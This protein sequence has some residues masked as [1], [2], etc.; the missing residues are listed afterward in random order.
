MS[1]DRLRLQRQLED[2][3]K[4]DGNT[5]WERF[6]DTVRQERQLV[7]ESLGRGESQPE[8][9]LRYL[10]GVNEALLRIQDFPRR[11]KESLEK[12]LR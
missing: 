6:W 9:H 11:I 7:L 1:K 5:F 10:Q 4:L 3:L 12:D 8:P 2:C